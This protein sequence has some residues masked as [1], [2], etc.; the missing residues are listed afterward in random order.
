MR[1]AKSCFSLSACG[2][3][4]EDVRRNARTPT[5][6]LTDE[7]ESVSL[8]TD[9]AFPH[10]HAVRFL[11]SALTRQKEPQ[12]LQTRSYKQPVAEG[13]GGKTPC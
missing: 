11:F 9:K 13:V 12:K 8:S 10:S 2:S 4:F 7:D 5:H 6:T 1:H 3:V